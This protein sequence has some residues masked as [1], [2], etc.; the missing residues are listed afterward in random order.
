MDILGAEDIS[1]CQQAG[2]GPEEVLAVEAAA[3]LA[4]L[5]GAVSVVVEPEVDGSKSILIQ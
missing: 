1:P 4:A 2:A 5:V 3:A